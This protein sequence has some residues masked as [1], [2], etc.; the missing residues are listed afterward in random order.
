MCRA[1][2]SSWAGLGRASAS[3]VSAT[4]GRGGFGAV[5]VSPVG[6]GA[7]LP[8]GGRLGR[9]SLASVDRDAAKELFDSLEKATGAAG[10]STSSRG[11]SGAGGGAV[12]ASAGTNGG[13]GG[14]GERTAAVILGPDSWVHDVLADEGLVDSDD[15]VFP[16]E[17]GENDLIEVPEGKT[18][19]EVLAMLEE[20]GLRPRKGS[21]SGSGSSSESGALT[22]SSEEGSTSDSASEDGEKLAAGS[23]DDDA[24]AG[25]SDDAVEAAG[26][27]G[28]LEDSDAD[29]EGEEDSEGT[30]SR[31]SRGL[32]RRD[33]DAPSPNLHDED[34]DPVFDPD[35]DYEDVFDTPAR[36]EF[37]SAPCDWGSPRHET[38]YIKRLRQAVADRDLDQVRVC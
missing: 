14:S 23:G 28:E 13:S 35:E 15:E 12:S 19:E 8:G 26:V 38:L 37:M 3:A 7:V 21:D 11:G 17:L 30:I 2:V 1:G 16:G 29:V 33:L 4:G 36:D 22:S 25:D 34:G 32:R 6:C 18:A 20:R 9:R 10:A 31:R 27:D 5:G 24:E